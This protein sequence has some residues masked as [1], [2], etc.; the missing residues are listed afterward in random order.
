MYERPMM[1]AAGTL[2]FSRDVTVD[3]FLSLT[4]CGCG[5]QSF[6]E[7]VGGNKL[8][9]N[10]RYLFIGRFHGFHREPIMVE[11][12]VETAKQTAVVKRTVVAKQAVAAKQEKE[13][14]GLGRLLGIAGGII[15]LV[16]ALLPWVTLSGPG[17]SSPK[18]F[19]G[20]STGFFGVMVSQ[21]GFFGIMMMLDGKK[22][23]SLGGMV[24]GAS[25]LVISVLTLA[26][27]GILSVGYTSG[28][29]IDVGLGIYVCIVGSTILLIGSILALIKA[30][31]PRKLPIPPS[32]A[33]KKGK[34][35]EALVLFAATLAGT[36]LLLAYPWTYG[37][38]DAVGAI[39]FL[40]GLIL[41]PTSYY[42]F[43]VEYWTWGTLLMVVILILLF[44]ILAS[45]F[46]LLA[47]VDALAIILYLTQA[48]YGV[49]VWKIDLAREEEHRKAREVVRVANPESLHCPRCKSSDVYICEDGS[50][51][52]R[53]CKTGFVNIHDMSAK[54]RSSMQGV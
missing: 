37:N 33:A 20:I 27:L 31:K 19:L 2:I 36:V 26:F 49:G 54:P 41:A 6:P 38:A 22:T 10:Q 16:G 47:Y 44:A 17:L 29:S 13:K 45:T 40:Y 42:V 3:R 51:Y 4:P 25:G 39:Y 30:G 8:T 12:K 34:P 53:S 35:V 32:K 7:K 18:M 50:T 43:K 11:K 15:A 28:M 9:G 52:C 5:L 1:S 23:T 14:I 24:L 21:L 46:V 48:T